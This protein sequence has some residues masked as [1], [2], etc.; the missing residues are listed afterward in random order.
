M[1]SSTPVPVQTV[2]DPAYVYELLGAKQVGLVNDLG[3]NDDD[4]LGAGDTYEYLLESAPPLDPQ[5]PVWYANGLAIPTVLMRQLWDVA[6]GQWSN[7][8]D[9]I[10]RLDISAVLSPQDVVQIQALDSPQGAIHG[11]PTPV[12]LAQAQLLTRPVVGLTTFSSLPQAF[13]E[14]YDDRGGKYFPN[15]SRRRRV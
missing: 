1:A 14:Q 7:I 5:Y 8:A 10:L 12:S 13:V 2:P 11:Q 3:I 9:T 15:T 4:T 6:L